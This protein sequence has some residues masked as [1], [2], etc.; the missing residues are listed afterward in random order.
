M[1][2]HRSHPEHRYPY[3]NGIT[4]YRQT[5][6]PS[7]ID[8]IRFN[9]ETLFKLNPKPTQIP[10]PIPWYVTLRQPLNSEQNRTK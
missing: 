1:E 8:N 4:S 9:P 10:L 2:T 7:K 6:D 5:F 3:D